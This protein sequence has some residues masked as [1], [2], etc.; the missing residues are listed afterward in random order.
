MSNYLL[1]FQ[2]ESDAAFGRG[3]GVAGVVDAEVQHDD[4]GCPYLGGRAL[5]G[6]LVQECADILAALPPATRPRWDNAAA[7]IFGR[8]GSTLGDAAIMSVGNAQLPADLRRAVE[9]DVRRDQIG[10][11][12]V[13]ESLTAVR[14]RTAIEQSGVPKPGSL[15]TLRVVLRGT[16]FEA[17][18]RFAQEPT[19]YD[20]ALL[21]ACVK[22][23]RSAGT[24]VHRGSGRLKAHL[25]DP[26]RERI[27]DR[28]FANFR[29]GV[30]T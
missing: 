10:R 15:R 1:E 28:F 23:F 26:A 25:L 16:R 22:A 6:L 13:L 17:A 21:A 9:R 24:G 19:E 14:A 7:R 20:L 3:D 29:A 8:P 4:L 2:L 5:K 18:L 30:T 12:Q 11:T 27:E